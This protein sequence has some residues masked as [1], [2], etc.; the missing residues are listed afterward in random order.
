MTVETKKFSKHE[1]YVILKDYHWMLREI[2]MI[3][4]ELATTDFRGVSQYGIEATLPHAK[5]I[6]G[7]A[8]EN[9]VIRRNKK[10]KRLLDYAEKINF[11]HANAY[12]VTDEKEKVVLDRLLDGMSIAGIA[13]HM[14]ISRQH[15][16]DLRDKVVKRLAE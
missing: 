16:H 11:I 15:A 8:I 14:R 2:K 3:D 4:R 12:K 9:E 1:I 5:G 7:K 6:V 13:H 10:S